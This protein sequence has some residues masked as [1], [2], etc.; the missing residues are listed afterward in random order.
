MPGSS[1]YVARL[2]YV[3][4]ERS[5]VVFKYPAGIFATDH[6]LKGYWDYLSIYL[7]GAKTAYSCG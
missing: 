4:L 1:Q 6:A 7:I 5:N 2:L 3:T